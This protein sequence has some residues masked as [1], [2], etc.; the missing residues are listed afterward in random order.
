MQSKRHSPLKKNVNPSPII[1]PLI[2]EQNNLCNE[3]SNNC[4]ENNGADLELIEGEDIINFNVS[5]FYPKESGQNTGGDKKSN[6]KDNIINHS[7]TG[8]MKYKVY[9]QYNNSAFNKNNNNSDNYSQFNQSN[10]NN[11]NSFINVENTGL[12]NMNINNDMNKGK[13]YF[14]PNKNINNCFVGGKINPINFQYNN[15]IFNNNNLAFFQNNINILN[16]PPIYNNY[17]LNNNYITQKEA[18]S[19]IYSWNQIQYINK[20]TK[21]KNKKIKKKI[22]DEYTIEMFGRRGWI[23]QYCNNFNFNSRKK[24][25]RCHLYINRK[26]IEDYLL[27]ENSKKKEKKNK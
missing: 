19:N 27:E 4:D 26:R 3:Q 18:L 15:T 12:N 24:C 23:C 7:Q 21:N 6:N 14:Y 8:E 10:H 11:Q 16:Y 2:Q 20:Q 5:F 22:I 1:G 13:N 9:N 17:M 25:N